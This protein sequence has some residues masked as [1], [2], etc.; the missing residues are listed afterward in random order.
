VTLIPSEKERGNISRICKISKN[1]LPISSGQ[2]LLATHHSSASYSALIVSGI[3]SKN[4]SD[5][6]S[7]HPKKGRNKL[8]FRPGKERAK[9]T[10]SQRV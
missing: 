7:V 6:I 9:D 10:Q 4:H 1:I 2:F 8:S 3:P 5:P